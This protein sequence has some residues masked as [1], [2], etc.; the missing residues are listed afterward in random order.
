MW[1]LVIVL[2]GVLLSN[3]VAG[4]Q[5]LLKDPEGKTIAVVL[6]CN[7]CKDPKPGA[8]CASGVESGFHDGAACGQCLLDANFGTRISYAY[9]LLITG[10][11]K[12]EKGEPVKNKFVK[13]FL[14]NTWTV[15]TRTTDQGMF[16]LMLGATAERKGKS[17]TRDLGVRTMRRDSKAE[18]YALYMLPEGY[19]PCA[20]EKK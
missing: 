5:D 7:A 17:L 18:L 8:Q 19:K 6:D 2:S 9:D 20:D 1:I 14:P 3:P 4:S 15:R 11:L 10:Y 13:L 12:D 16:R